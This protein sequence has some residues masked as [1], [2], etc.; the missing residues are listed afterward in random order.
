MDVSVVWQLA[1][2][3]RQINFYLCPPVAF[4]SA[5]DRTRSDSDRF[6][7]F[8]RSVHCSFDLAGLVPGRARYPMI[9]PLDSARR[10]PTAAWHLP[11]HGRFTILPA[12]VV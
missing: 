11:R 1:I 6:G 7:R 10:L 4:A 12:D 2:V 9:A 5:N 3:Y 8:V